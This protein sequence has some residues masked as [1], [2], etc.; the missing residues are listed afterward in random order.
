MT[1]P[2]LKSAES[3]PQNPL[4]AF[5]IRHS[6]AGVIAGFL[7]GGILP[8]AF[9][10]ITQSRDRGRERIDV[11]GEIG[12]WI[13]RDIERIGVTAA[14][15]KTFA[16]PGEVQAAIDT[17]QLV[18]DDALALS[19]VREAKIQRSFGKA[20]VG[21]YSAF[22]ESTRSL[23]NC[24]R[25]VQTRAAVE[26]PHTGDRANIENACTVALQDIDKHANILLHVLAAGT[27]I[28]AQ[29]LDWINARVSVDGVRHRIDITDTTPLHVAWLAPRASACQMT[30]PEQS[31]IDIIG[32]SQ[33]EP[34][35]PWFPRAGDSTTFSIVC[36][37]GWT[38]SYDSIIVARR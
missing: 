7:L 19:E 36:T 15:Q 22:I 32:T 13:R 33:I 12:P 1:G 23:Q 26:P 16:G 31:G 34:S 6:L 4:T 25:L 5:I 11:A 9:F 28:R 27:G 30:A 14:L 10:L 37:N 17:L 38:N 2:S 18:I 20:G 24:F 29:P 3:T 35:H 21:A 8:T